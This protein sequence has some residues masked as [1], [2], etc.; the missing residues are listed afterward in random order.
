MVWLL[1]PFVLIV[2]IITA[3]TIWSK[4]VMIDGQLDRRKGKRLLLVMS[5]AILFSLASLFNIFQLQHSLLRGLRSINL[6]SAATHTQ[7]SIPFTMCNRQTPFRYDINTYLPP[8]K[9]KPILNYQINDW[10]KQNPVLLVNLSCVF[11]IFTF[12]VL[13]YLLSDIWIEFDFWRQENVVP[14]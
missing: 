13:S 14:F 2:V 11:S 8:S 6:S 5:A 12:Q 3:D 1:V 10:T 7:E 9:Q 4:E